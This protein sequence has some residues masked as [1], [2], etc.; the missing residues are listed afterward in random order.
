[1]KLAK[2]ELDALVAWMKAEKLTQQAVGKKL[3]VTHV[4]VMKWVNGGGIRPLQL[5]RLRPLISPHIKM[6]LSTQPEAELSKLRSKLQSHAGS[7]PELVQ[8][9]LAFLD[10]LE[11]FLARQ[12]QD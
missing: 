11:D 2:Y 12:K 3:N 7:H 5:A 8:L 1:M 9:H 10:Q 4:S 6:D